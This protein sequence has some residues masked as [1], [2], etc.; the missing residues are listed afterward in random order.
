M[1]KPDGAA[2]AVGCADRDAYMRP[3]PVVRDFSH[4]YGFA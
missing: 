3:M 4:R 2:K 1:L